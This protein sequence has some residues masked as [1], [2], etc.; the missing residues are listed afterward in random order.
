V[1]AGTFAVA[2]RAL[3]VV[4]G[5]LAAAVLIVIIAG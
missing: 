3:H 1:V 2:S 5:A 4:A